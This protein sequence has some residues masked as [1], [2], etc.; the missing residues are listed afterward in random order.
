MAKQ[1]I[2]FHFLFGSLLG[3]QLI[4]TSSVTHASAPEC[5]GIL[6]EVEKNAL[7]Q[8]LEAYWREFGHYPKSAPPVE[9]RRNY[10][11]FLI[12]HR[13]VWT[14]G[15]LQ[16]I[17]RRSLDVTPKKSSILTSKLLMAFLNLLYQ[18]PDA[19]IPH[20]SKPLRDF[21]IGEVTGDSDSFSGLNPAVA[22]HFF[23][24][25]AS[26]SIDSKESVFDQFPSS[27]IP[28]KIIDLFWRGF[29][30]YQRDGRISPEVYQA[31]LAWKSEH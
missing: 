26:R 21:I 15:D 24:I 19:R 3:L 17:I 12:E 7:I 10:Q 1:L 6:N 11:N 16:M 14:Q 8:N 5:G 22:T 18:V 30:Q 28:Q 29:N 27:K 25:Q 2:P 9:V 31:F 4:Q 23:V 20:F 13:D